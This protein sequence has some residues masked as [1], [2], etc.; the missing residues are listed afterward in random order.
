MK[1]NVIFHLM[2]IYYHD[3]IISP[4][5]FRPQIF[6]YKSEETGKTFLWFQGE[7]KDKYLPIKTGKVQQFNSRSYV[8]HA[9]GLKV[10]PKD[11]QLEGT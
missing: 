6:S 5:V 1:L 2:L 4:S 7:R 10:N 9:K 11:F 8:L 3:G